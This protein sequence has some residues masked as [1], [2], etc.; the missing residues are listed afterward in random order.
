MPHASGLRGGAGRLSLGTGVHNFDANNPLPTVDG[1]IA[2]P[3]AASAG[4]GF[5]KVTAGSTILLAADNRLKG[6]P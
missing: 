4:G 5:K 2:V 3:L 6:N 1:V